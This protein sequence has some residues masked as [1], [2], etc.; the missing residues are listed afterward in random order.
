LDSL[1]I[2][3]QLLA[4]NTWIMEHELLPYNGLLSD[5]KIDKERL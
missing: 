1:S 5:K 3:V 2:Y 4:L